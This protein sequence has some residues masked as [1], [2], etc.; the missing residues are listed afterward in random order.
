[1]KN[2]FDSKGYSNGDPHTVTLTPVNQ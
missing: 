2:M 1:M